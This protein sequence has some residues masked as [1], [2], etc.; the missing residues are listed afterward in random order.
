MEKKK[1][2]EIEIEEE[3]EMSESEMEIL[4]SLLFT[5]WKREFESEENNRNEN[6][7]YGLRTPLYVPRRESNSEK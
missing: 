4:A 3:R 6:D 2:I 7:K 1:Q 5:W